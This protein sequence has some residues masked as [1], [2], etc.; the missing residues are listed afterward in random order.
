MEKLRVAALSSG[1]AGNCFYV[2]NDKESVLIDAGISTKRIIERMEMLGLDVT[3]VKGIFITHEHTDHIKGTDVF[4][5][6]FNVPV[7]ATKGT[8]DG[9]G[10]CSEEKFVNSFKSGEKFKIGGLGVESFSKSHKAADPVSYSVLGKNGK[11]VSIITDL[12]FACEN[13]NNAI[14]ESDF[15][16]LESNHDIEMLENGPYPYFLKK[17]IRSDIG[18]LSNRQ[19]SL[20]V[21][22]Y[23]S[24]KLK[25]VVLSHLSEHNNS[26]EVALKTFND[27]MKERKGFDSDVSVSL[28]DGPTE[29]FRV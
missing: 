29:L 12:G 15:L 3:K 9:G 6:K 18:H 22:E 27:L 4:A 2:G 14:G 7:Y 20:A 28:K 17:W 13:V 5:R 16:F 26:P 23:S 19:A 25:N 24:K 10:I 8:I 1:S 21:L 11:N